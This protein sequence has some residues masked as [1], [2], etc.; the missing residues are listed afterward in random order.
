MAD[1]SSGPA[2]PGPFI[3]L[4]A[5]EQTSAGLRLPLERALV[6]RAH[7]TPQDSCKLFA[8]FLLWW[9]GFSRN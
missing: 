2:R 6:S 5:V 3:S 8:C 7:G 1:A 9:K 4:L